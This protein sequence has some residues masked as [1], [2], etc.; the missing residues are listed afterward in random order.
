MRLGS[1]LNARF[2]TVRRH[3]HSAERYV[4]AQMASD[5]PQHPSGEQVERAY[6]E[7]S[8]A[9]KREEAARHFAELFWPVPRTLAWIGFREEAFIDNSLPVLPAP[10]IRDWIASR[11]EAPS[12]AWYATN[13]VGPIRDTDP[14]GTL[15]RALQDG[16]IS[17]LKDGKELPRE[18]WAGAD[19]RDW[20]IVH[21]RR[22]DALALWP[23]ESERIRKHEMPA[24]PQ[25]LKP[26][27]ET[28][29]QPFSQWQAES[30]ALKLAPKPEISAAIKA[31]YDAADAVG[32]KPPN[33]K[34]LAAAV[35]PRLKEKGYRASGR[36][37]QEVGDAQEFKR[38]RRQPG[39]TISSE[40]RSQQK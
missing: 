4:E 20:P 33:I 6:E 32:G 1:L 13:A 23:V 19:G 12:A 35:L 9:M 24:R 10:L 39:K 26:K 15:L 14:Q 11:D 8:K 40:Q 16:S 28:P 22:E 25:R 3:N 5:T 36:A 2:R 37:I 29:S 21:F 27:V 38:R 34:E 31:T 30:L 18:A 17:A 7:H